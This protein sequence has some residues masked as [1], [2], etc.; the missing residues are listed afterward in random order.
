MWEKKN[1]LCLN[2]QNGKYIALA[3]FFSVVITLNHKGIKCV[4]EYYD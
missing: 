2:F 4:T 1:F 3:I